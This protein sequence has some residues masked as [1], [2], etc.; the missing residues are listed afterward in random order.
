[1]LY[2]NYISVKMRQRKRKEG[3]GKRKKGG[4]E[5]GKK[6]RGRE[7]GR[8]VDEAKSLKVTI[9]KYFT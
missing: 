6:K 8:R 5:E 7:G 4:R 3:K 1:M 2:V 9:T